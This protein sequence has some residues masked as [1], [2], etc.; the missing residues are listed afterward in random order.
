M[1]SRRSE[2]KVCGYY[3]AFDDEDEKT[4]SNVRGPEALPVPGVAEINFID[5]GIPP[6]LLPFG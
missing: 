4:Q 3:E 6:A 1:W 5:P 2:K